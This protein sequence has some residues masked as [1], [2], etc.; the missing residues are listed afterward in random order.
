MT[1]GILPLC[2]PG[3][4][5]TTTDCWSVMNEVTVLQSWCGTRITGS[6]TAARSRLRTVLRFRFVVRSD[7]YINQ[8][9]PSFNR[10]KQPHSLLISVT[11]CFDC[12][13]SL[14]TVQRTRIR[15]ALV[16]RDGGGPWLVPADLALLKKKRKETPGGL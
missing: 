12:H 10:P 14:R 2:S 8:D 7:E 9:H 15:A 6:P 5:T 3:Q 16:Q 11:G 13:C 4:T 1:P